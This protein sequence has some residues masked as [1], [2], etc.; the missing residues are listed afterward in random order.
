MSKKILQKN[1]LC[2]AGPA[3]HFGM[4]L[5]SQSRQSCERKGAAASAKVEPLRLKNDT[6]IWYGEN[7]FDHSPEF[8]S[9]SLFLQ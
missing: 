2:M 3:N 8:F 6:S 5:A 9:T 7:C 4:D 1:I